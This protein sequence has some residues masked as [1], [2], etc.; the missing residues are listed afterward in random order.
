MQFSEKHEK[1]LDN[2][3]KTLRR[4]QVPEITGEEML[5]FT[6]G[7]VVVQ[8]IYNFIKKNLEEQKLRQQIAQSKPLEPTVVKAPEKPNVSKRKK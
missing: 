5:A 2:V 3:L 1:A 7:Y 6:S 4:C 8:E